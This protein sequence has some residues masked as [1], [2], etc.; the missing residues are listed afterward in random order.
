M[1]ALIDH[2]AHEIWKLGMDEYAP[3]TDAQ[4]DDVEYHAIQLAAAGPLLSVGGTGPMDS[5]WVKSPDWVKHAKAMTDAGV[6]AFQASQKRDRAALVSIG[7]ELTAAC[8]DC[9]KQFK[10]DLPTEGVVHLHDHDVPDPPS[11]PSA[12]Q[13]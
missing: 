10:P 7:D 2:S 9:H 4:W 8:E 6:R 12:E 1:V 11:R 13:K 5:T 3:K